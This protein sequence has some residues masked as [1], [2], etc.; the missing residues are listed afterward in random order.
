MPLELYK[1]NEIYWIKGRIDEL[2]DSK[3]YRRSTHKSSETSAVAVRNHF[4]QEELRRFYG[5]KDV[6]ITFSEAVLHYKSK[7]EIAK[8]L[9]PIVETIG[10]I[11]V[12]R[13]TPKFIR[14][15]GHELQ[16]NNG[17][18]T[19]QKRIVSPIRAVINNAHEL[20]LCAPLK[21]KSYRKGERLEQ[22]R[23]RNKTSRAE[24]TPGS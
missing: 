20:G 19:W 14:N 22:D 1:R 15:L 16:P 3:Y 23:K 4:Q 8:A 9:I 12:S 21:V 5:G 17:T 24:K 7:P 6:S 18:D 10:E 13:I 2:P 11:E